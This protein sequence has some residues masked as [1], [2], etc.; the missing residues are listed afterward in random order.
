MTQRLLAIGPM[1]LMA[2]CSGAALSMVGD[3]PVPPQQV[4]A[5]TRL[6]PT[7]LDYLV[8]AS[9]ATAPRPLAMASYR[10][11]AARAESR[12]QGNQK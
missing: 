2:S 6:A 5:P 8:L 9:M 3:R 12:A 7:R 11:E 1:L 10:P 4:I